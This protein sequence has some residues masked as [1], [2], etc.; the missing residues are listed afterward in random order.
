MSHRVKSNE[1]K[2]ELILYSLVH[3][4]FLVSGQARALWGA[5]VLRHP[6]RTLPPMVEKQ[7]VQSQEMARQ[8]YAR[9]QNGDREAS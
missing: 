5:G 7:A 6:L 4:Q 9:N 1:S 8:G 3:R 2:C